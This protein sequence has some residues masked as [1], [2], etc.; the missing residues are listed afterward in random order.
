MEKPILVDFGSVELQTNLHLTEKLSRRNEI[1]QTFRLSKPKTMEYKVLESSNISD[2]YSSSSNFFLDDFLDFLQPRAYKDEEI[3][4]IQLLKEATL[5]ACDMSNKNLAVDQKHLLVSENKFDGIYDK[6]SEFNLYAYQKESVIK[7]LKNMMSMVGNDSLVD[8]FLTLHLNEVNEKLSFLKDDVKIKKIQPVRSNM[9]RLQNL[10]MFII[11]HRN[12]V[13][14]LQAQIREQDAISK[15]EIQELTVMNDQLLQQSQLQLWN[16]NNLQVELEGCRI[17]IKLCDAEID[18]LKGEIKLQGD[19]NEIE[20]GV[21]LFNDFQRQHLERDEGTQNLIQNLKARDLQECIVELGLDLQSCNDETHKLK[22]E[23]NVQESPKRSEERKNEN[24][25]FSWTK[26]SS[27]LREKVEK[28]TKELIS[29]QSKTSRLETEKAVWIQD[30][31]SLHLAA[32]S[33]IAS[34]Q[35]C[36]SG[37]KLDIIGRDIEIGKLK[38]VSEKDKNEI[39]RLLE[40]V[41]MLS[42]DV[43]IIDC[44]ATGEIQEQMKYK[45]ISLRLPSRLP[46][47]NNKKEQLQNIFKAPFRPPPNFKSDRLSSLSKKHLDQQLCLSCVVDHISLGP[48]SYSH[49]KGN[50]CSQLEQLFNKQNYPS[51]KSCQFAFKSLECIISEYTVPESDITFSHLA[52]D[53]NKQSV[54]VYLTRYL[55]V[56]Y[57]ST[58]HNNFVFLTMIL[59][60]IIVNV[61]IIIYCCI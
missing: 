56:V 31:D 35:R 1:F 8:K 3:I 48:R 25:N 32:E 18:K 2:N 14:S 61:I 23:I 55:G 38:T 15:R 4:S 36:C 42:N 47:M 5:E 17:D 10:K 20:R 59:V 50:L 19:S 9:K 40:I 45:G 6:D 21:E 26:Q 54:E 29:S 58:C 41:K 33:K 49:S 46:S 28:L 16:F 44:T 22:V 34:L 30:T 13:N 27:E 43:K 12:K 39:G 7:E 11:S 24:R 60:I 52:T 37:F 51:R 53:K 57:Y